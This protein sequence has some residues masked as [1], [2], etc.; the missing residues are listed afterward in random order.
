MKQKEITDT[1]SHH[2]LTQRERGREG[3]PAGIQQQQQWETLVADVKAVDV[4]PLMPI[5]TLV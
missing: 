2:T 1:Q 5:H 3:G 4:T